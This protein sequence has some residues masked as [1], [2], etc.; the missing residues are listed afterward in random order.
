MVYF[1]YMKTF[2]FPYATFIG[3]M[4]TLILKTKVHNYNLTANKFKLK[5]KFKYL[6]N[7]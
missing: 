5:I 2:P 7:T 1:T 6:M 4:H 3:E